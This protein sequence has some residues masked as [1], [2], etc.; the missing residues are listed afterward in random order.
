MNWYVIGAFALVA[1]C[2]VGLVYKLVRTSKS[3]GR[4]EALAEQAGADKD[5]TEKLAKK[6]A[7]KATSRLD[8]VIKLRKWADKLPK[9][10]S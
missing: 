9:R 3:A 2:I 10:G 6:F 1:V 4:S 5:A 7:N 8:N